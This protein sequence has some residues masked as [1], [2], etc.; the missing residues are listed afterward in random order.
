MNNIRFLWSCLILLILALSIAFGIHALI[1]ASKELS[2]FGDLL[3]WSYLINLVLAFG[4]VVLIHSLRNRMKT[5]LGF[6]FMAGS[7]V[8]FLIFFLF[9]YPSF[10]ADEVINQNEFSSFFVPYFL[11]L[12]IETYF[13]AV[14]LKNLE[15]ENP[16]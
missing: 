3:A 11:A 12:I 4:I 5:Q 2:P 16:G 1:R 9:F 13:S 15:K 10:T 7:F 8:K 14:L 6:L